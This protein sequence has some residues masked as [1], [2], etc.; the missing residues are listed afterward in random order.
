MA[1]LCIWDI[2]LLEDPAT[3]HALTDGI[4]LPRISPQMAPFIL[5]LRQI[6]CTAPFEEKAAQSMMF[7]PPCLTVGMVCSYHAT[8]HYSLPNMVYNKELLLV[9]FDYIIFYQSSSG[10]S[11]WFL[12]NF[13]WSWT[14]STLSGG[15]F[16]TT[17]C[18]TKSNLC[19]C[20]SN[21]NSL[22]VVDLLHSVVRGFS[23]TIF[24]INCIPPGE[25]LHDCWGR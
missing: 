6:S 7:P 1:W 10:S 3:F 4:F 9:S 24:K 14:C 12:V 15:T 22:K 18:V 2:V 17:L 21:S 20:D 25:N 16:G 8:L 23:L 13:R 11:T 5:S 19:Y